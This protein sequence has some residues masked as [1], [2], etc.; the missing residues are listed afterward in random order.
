MS[1]ISIK[2]ALVLLF[3]FIFLGFL[4]IEY[5]IEELYKGHDK[6]IDSLEQKIKEKDSLIQIEK[7]Y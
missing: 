2:T 4:Y 7:N 1:K 3:I 6:K 5:Q